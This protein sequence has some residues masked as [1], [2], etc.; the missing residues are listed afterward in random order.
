MLKS[1]NKKKFRREHQAELELYEAAVKF[2]KEE[3]A[4]GKIPSMKSLK[5]EKEK[6]TLSRTATYIRSDHTQGH[7]IS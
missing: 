1:R 5:S 7:T 2:L 3:N 4:N 6:L